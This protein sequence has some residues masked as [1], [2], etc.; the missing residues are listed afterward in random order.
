MQP[1]SLKSLEDI[2]I[3]AAFILDNASGKDIDGYLADELLRS[4][5]ER[6]FE[7]IGEAL[8]RL[9][10]NDA[11]TL[12]L[13][14]ESSQI[15]AFRNVLIHGYDAINHRRVWDAVQNSLPRLLEIVTTLLPAVPPGRSSDSD[16]RTNH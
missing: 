11:D 14:P 1:E 7:I 15:I 12:D 2:R 16:S 3:A 8:V 10:R 9:R 6:K 4:A 5:V 13:I